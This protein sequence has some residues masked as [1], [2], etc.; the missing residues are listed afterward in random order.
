MLAMPR[1]FVVL[2]VLGVSA[3]VANADL[4]NLGA[5][6]NYAVLGLGG[7]STLRSGFEVYQSGTVINGNVG[8]GAYSTFTH[9]MDATINGGLY[10]DTTDTLPIITG[11][12]TGGTHQQSML[13]TV[14]D[15]MSASVIA[16]GL[17][18]TQTFATL[19]EGQT[20]TGNGGNN[21][22]KVTGDVTLK[23]TLTINGTANDWFVFQM[24]GTG[25]NPLTLSGVIMNLTG[26]VTADHILWDLSGSG[27][28]LS[29]TSGGALVYGTFLAPDRSIIVDNANVVGRIIGGGTVAGES[30]ANSLSIHSTSNITLSPSTAVPEPS[31]WVLFGSTVV[32]VFVCC[33]KRWS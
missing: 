4:F 25:K 17:A 33:R 20:I 11:T 2:M 8:T 14:T 27:G 6:A 16:A 32:A 26:G 19:T 10:Y 29:I 30:P 3:P 23:T 28:G 5:A 24:D 7:V 31:S 22:I 18:P 15:A 21:V 9:G 13:Q 1:L 12:I